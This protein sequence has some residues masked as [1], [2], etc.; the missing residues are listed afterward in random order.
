MALEV[1]PNPDVAPVRNP[2][3]QRSLRDG[4]KN[5]HEVARYVLQQNH[6]R[7]YACDPCRT[8]RFI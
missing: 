1:R 6:D 7:D 4:I 2:Y 8:V 3:C 5:A